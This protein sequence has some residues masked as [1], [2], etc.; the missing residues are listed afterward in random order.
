MVGVDLP[1]VNLAQT[2]R[3]EIVST[4]LDDIQ[5]VRWLRGLDYLTA[6]IVVQV[7]A[8]EV[9][10]NTSAVCFRFDQLFGCVLWYVSGDPLH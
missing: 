7:Q 6:N 4:S 5:N 9:R 8:V 1:A 3:W 10:V 2:I